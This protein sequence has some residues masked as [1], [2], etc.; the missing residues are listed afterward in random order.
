MEKEIMLASKYQRILQKGVVVL[1]LLAVFQMN[2]QNI[3]LTAEFT[4]THDYNFDHYTFEGS[5][6]DPGTLYTWDVGDGI[7]TIS[8][9][10]S[11]FYAF[12]EKRKYT[13]CLKVSSPTSGKSISKC[14]EINNQPL[15]CDANFSI[16]VKKNTV[17]FRNISTGLTSHT[18]YKW[19]FGDG[20]YLN[21]RDGGLK[22]EHKGTYHVCLTITDTIFKCESSF[23]NYVTINET[24]CSTSFTSFRTQNSDKYKYQ[25]FP[26]YLVPDHTYS[27]DFGDGTKEDIININTS[28][29]VHTYAKGGLYN[30]CFTTTD[31]INECTSTTCIPI[32][33]TTCLADFTYT[34]DKATST[35]HFA[36]KNNG[37][38]A[39]YKWYFSVPNGSLSTS[40]LKE[41]DYQCN[42]PYLN[43]FLM[44]SSSSD[45][46]CHDTIYKWL[47]T[48]MGL[49]ENKESAIFLENY[50]NPFNGSTTIHYNIK[51]TSPVEISVFDLLGSRVDVIQSDSKAP[52]D[53]TIEWNAAHMKKGMYLL[54]LKTTDQSV[55]KKII[56]NK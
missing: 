25:F 6:N 56:I 28:N 31:P 2:A 9:H 12:S 24:D 29:I 14:I 49:F 26:S 34:F 33:V 13:I 52:G 5:D 42:G 17:F 55:T 50:P 8:T 4:Y 38:D 21:S 36:A 44:T 46:N 37:A 15:P 43:V 53:Y 22:Y 16:E 40:N 1:F 20:N 10:K 18:T 11:I 27:F 41:P 30:A 47:E 19:D 35:Y 7:T 3:P 23:C 48:P 32:S 45:S 39:I 54:Q 51:T